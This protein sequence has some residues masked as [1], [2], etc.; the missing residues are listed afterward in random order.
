MLFEEVRGVFPK[1]VH[2]DLPWDEVVAHVY[3]QSSEA[4]P[5]AVTLRLAAGATYPGCIHRHRTRLLPFFAPPHSVWVREGG[6]GEM[7]LRG[8]LFATA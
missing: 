8:C 1:R 4:L 2:A 6:M 3:L 7:G 5:H